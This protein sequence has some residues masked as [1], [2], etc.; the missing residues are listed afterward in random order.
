[1]FLLTSAYHSTLNISLFFSQDLSLV[2][3]QVTH[4]FQKELTFNHLGQ[5]LPIETA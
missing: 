3:I 4:I 2:V 5:I 1:M